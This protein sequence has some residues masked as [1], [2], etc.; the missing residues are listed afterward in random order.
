MLLVLKTVSMVTNMFVFVACPSERGTVLFE[1]R[2]CNMASAF[3]AYC[4][5][6]M[7]QIVSMSRYTYTLRHSTSRNLT[8]N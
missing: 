8:Q 2:M 4:L 1:G 3:A 7:A 5:K 6:S